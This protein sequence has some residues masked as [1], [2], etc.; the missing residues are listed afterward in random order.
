MFDVDF[1]GFPRRSLHLLL[2]ASPRAAARAGLALYDSTL[3]HQRVARALGS[4]LLSLRLERLLRL[5]ALPPS[6]L[7][8]TWWTHWCEQVAV[9]AVGPVD[10]AAFKL[11]DDRVVA[12][13][14]TA[15]GAPRGFVK[16]WRDPPG[17]HRPD[18]YMQPI[19]LE[20]LARARFAHFRVAPL[21]AEGTLDGWAYQ[22]FA[23]LP[24]GT[25][26][27]A[28]ASDALHIARIVDEMQAALADVPRDERVPA[29]HVI[30]HGD[31]TPRNVRRAADGAFWVLD[32]EYSGWSPRLADELQFWAS[33]FAARVR[34]H[35]LRDAGRVL[36]LLRTRAPDDA[37]VEA[38]RW[39]TY[40]TPGEVAIVRGVARQLGVDDV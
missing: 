31:F 29:S 28:T 14:M 25:H 4:A 18:P 13:L 1:L 27:P 15:S 21:L 23:P 11:S 5:G 3:L 38:V 8:R 6:V 39:K 22:L 9:P 40:M 10:L 37:I 26:R 24:P 32:W 16:T 19:V 20:R 12:L 36:A 34:P 35:P 7:D 2:P 30:G 17:P 33:A